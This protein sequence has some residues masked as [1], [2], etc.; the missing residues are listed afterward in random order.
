MEEFRIEEKIGANDIR[1]DDEFCLE[2]GREKETGFSGF[3]LLVFDGKLY[4]LV[5]GR[6]E[7][8]RCRTEKKPLRYALVVDLMGDRLALLRSLI[9]I[10]HETG[11][12]NVIEAAIA[13]KRLYCPS[14]NVAPDML[15]LLGI[16]GNERFI[17]G[18]VS[19]AGAPDTLKKL[20]LN[21]KLDILTAFEIFAF[22]R[23]DWVR[24]SRFAAGIKLGI[25][26]RNSLLSMIYDIVQR[27]GLEVER[28]I[29]RREIKDILKMQ[30]DPP[31]KGQKVYE[32]IERIRYP[33]ITQYKKKFY[34]TLRK[35]GMGP[36]LHLTIPQDFEQWN[37][38]ISFSFA[39]VD[40]FK[41]KVELLGT[42]GSK[43]AFQELMDL[44]Y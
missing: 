9:R 33:Y 20:V 19:L 16:P 25:K 7:V 6:D 14:K 27:D 34:E 26:K 30:I 8:Q 3:P 42:I 4:S 10:K 2:Y 5:S 1:T 35:V 41:R 38:S 21:G 22:E 39:S 37:F 24:V 44:R 18:Y 23:R 13:V 31:H 11:G 28:L 12:F 36:E 43:S 32:A 29:E 40:D 15:H 17:E